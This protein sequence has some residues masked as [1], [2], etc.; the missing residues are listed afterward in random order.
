MVYS[1]AK[2][3]A[4]IDAR[5]L[6]IACSEGGSAADW[7]EFTRRFGSKLTAG[8]KRAYRRA[9]A[10][11]RLDELEDLVQE[12]YCRLL[13]K[14]GRAL[15]ACRS[16]SEI[17]I[18]V[19]LSRVA[20]RVTIDHL[21]AKSAEKR[22]GGKIE[23][24]ET[25]TESEGER[26]WPVTEPRAEDRLLGRERMARFLGC[27][28]RIVGRRKERDLRILRLALLEGLTSREISQRF[29]ILISPNGVDT[30]LHRARARLAAEGFVLPRRR[31]V[32]AT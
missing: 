31:P 22:G 27:C 8:V 12:S 19:Y 1:D 2:T 3:N 25:I 11:P 6:L 26:A 18:G 4:S 30:V 5:S 16:D 17:A 14:R 7:R 24:L 9:G 29:G 13:E 15:R 28:R 32:R 10:R 21:R 20:E 23:S